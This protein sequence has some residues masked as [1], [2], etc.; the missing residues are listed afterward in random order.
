V[1][2]DWLATRR[3]AIAA[4]TGGLTVALL[5]G[6]LLLPR[7]L[8]P[9]A[10]GLGVVF[11]SLDALVAM[12]LVLIFRSG[13]IIN[14][15]QASFGGLAAAVMVIMVAGWHVPYLLAVPVGLGC[16]LS[17]GVA[18]DRV[19]VRRLFNSPRLLL[20]VA[21][22]GVGQVVAAIQLGLP[23]IL[24]KKLNAFTTYQTPLH[25]WHFSIHT[26]YF[27]GD[28]VLA[29]AVV[30]V[31]L[32]ALA[33]FLAR[34]DLG[35]AIRAMAD[36]HERA[37]LLGIPVATLSLVSW[38][39]A[40]GLSGLGTILA[41]PVEGQN[42]GQVIGPTG[43]LVPLAA[44]VIARM[45]SLPVAFAAAVGIDVAEQAIFWSH[46]RSSSVDLG[47]FVIVLVSLLAQRRRMGRLANLVSEHL[48]VKEIRPVPEALKRLPS[49]QVGRSAL[50]LVVAA[51]AAVVL[52]YTMSNSQLFIAAS[53]AIFG[54]V[55]VSLVPLSGWA[56]QISLGQFA[57]AGTGA[58]TT[59]ALLVHF[60]VDLFIALAAS[61]VVG[62]LVALVI[63]IPALRIPGTYLAVVTLAFAVPVSS[64][65]LSASY[66]PA[67]NP[68][69]VVRPNLFGR[70]SL[71]SPRAFY[72]LC[73][74]VLVVV[75]H[76][77]RNLRA[78]RAGR[79]IVATRDNEHAAASFSVSPLRTKLMVFVYS[80]A[81][82]AVA[83][84]LYVVANRG[85]GF[86]GIDPELSID[87]FLM[88][89]IGGLG[90][91]TG[92][93]LGVVYVE[94]VQ[95]LLPTSVQ[96]LA[97]GGGLL[98]LLL[99]LPGGLGQIFF[100]TRDR[101]LAW[102]AR[103]HR[104]EISALWGAVQFDQLDD[105]A[106]AAGGARQPVA[107]WS[108]GTN[109][110]GLTGLG[111]PLLSCQGVG[112]AYGP[113][114]VLFGV[115]ME[116]ARSEIVG[117]L[118]TNGAG[119]STLLRVISGLMPLRDGW[120]RFDGRDLGA[121]SPLERVKRGV[122]TVP[123]GR[124]IFPSLTVA[125]NL[126]VAGWRARR[127][128]V[129]PD[130]AIER[131]LLLF[132]ALRQR[133]HAKAATLSGGEQQM[134][135]ISQ[136]LLCS[137][138]L[139]LIDELSLGLAPIV[140]DSLLAAVRQLAR[141]GVTV[142]IVE[143]S[144]NVAIELAERAVF[145]ERGQIR[146]SGPTAELAG[147]N[148]LLRSVFLATDRD[149][150]ATGTSPVGTRTRRPPS[151]TANGGHPE[152]VF[153]VEDIT[154]RFGM[155]AAL[156]DVSFSV[157]DGEI[158]GIIGSNGAGKTT[159]F[160][161]CSGFLAP[162]RGRVRMHGQDV[163][164]MSAPAR[165]ARGM[166]RVFQDAR[167]FPSLT[168]TEVVAVAFERHIRVRDPLLCVAGMGSV[169]RS[170]AEVA[171]GVEELLELVHLTRYRDSFVSELSTGTR[172]IV[173]LACTMAHEPSLLLLD[174]PSSGV[175]QRETEAL[176]QMLIDLQA[177][178]GVT[179]VLIE[180]DMPLVSSISDR[181]ICMHLGGAL[182]AGTPDQVLADP[183]VMASYLGESD[184]AIH[185]SGPR[186]MPH[187]PMEVVR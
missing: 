147:R 98:L 16:A 59:G 157:S 89:A 60:N 37:V 151:P 39:M 38:M 115:D 156:S 144:V 65:F 96:L 107:G 25:G 154:K 129:S 111:E 22:I 167:L 5:A 77:T 121:L 51:V 118:G 166:G 184:V 4:W 150:H 185:R 126:S 33:W 28:A 153:A 56:G 24:D 85:I 101:V 108:P 182:S 162:D 104:I 91:T 43:L 42:L 6:E 73:L 159:L 178:T 138:K 34:T 68:T 123:G 29:V 161:V 15:A 62:G 17:C 7:G 40:A 52:P 53:A 120:L 165:A 82:A 148:D 141:D 102:L 72:W 106:R 140:V 41:V 170:E 75:L 9:G 187:E 35:L 172:R 1:I 80:G 54:I 113:I 143:Q 103:R 87:V 169:R 179:M 152:P 124:G 93:I 86:S 21:T 97:T 139:L 8:D 176:A 71:Q 48:A 36:S 49:Y 50:W 160:D 174:E 180:H 183:A 14:F 30:L 168:V 114:Q 32:V 163:T 61:A 46:P 99:L 149:H 171:E 20:T 133:W 137:P 55:A 173:E 92:A 57:L 47:V 76:L 100:G 63:G 74:G 70:V 3:T 127:D 136:S 116:V 26:T 177:S 12:G 31:V 128:G 79:V 119:K 132:P 64:Y 117:L 69:D 66:F 131:A 13:R 158:L 164:G 95:F 88:V 112:A 23:L 27:T 134:L 109:G 175:A 125:E 145:M 135:T 181:L 155:V 94:M 122:V 67:I 44:A 19:V 18:T 83:G 146:F 142:V 78:S 2:T 10:V 58:A 105:A 11:G 45:E 130:A 81:V 84:G 110:T 186:A 90:S